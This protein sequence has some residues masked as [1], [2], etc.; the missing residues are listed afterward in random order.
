M[1]KLLSIVDGIYSAIFKGLIK[2]IPPSDVLDGISNNVVSVGNKTFNALSFACPNV[3]YLV[4]TSLSQCECQV[5]GIKVTMSLEYNEIKAVFMH[6]KIN[7]IYYS[8]SN[9]T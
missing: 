9:T 2:N 5:N 6:F 1:T 3:E 7:L 4:D 8:N